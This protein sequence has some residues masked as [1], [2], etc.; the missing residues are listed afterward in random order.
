MYS[1]H[2]RDQYSLLALQGIATAQKAHVT[3][4]THV[5]YTRKGIQEDS[6]APSYT[7]YRLLGLSTADDTVS[8]NHAALKIEERIRDIPTQ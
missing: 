1:S 5:G 3:H 7:V 2:P 4:L 6:I 8:L